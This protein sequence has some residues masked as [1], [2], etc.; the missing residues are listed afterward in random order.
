MAIL[1]I[2]AMISFH[3]P[4][5]IAAALPNLVDTTFAFSRSGF[6]FPAIGDISGEISIT[7]SSSTGVYV[8]V[9][10]DVIMFAQE[11]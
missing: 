6:R 4:F 8:R 3:I 2:I 7:K 10:E 9:R 11:Q 5:Q 1:I